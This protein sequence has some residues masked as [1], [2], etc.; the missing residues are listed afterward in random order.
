[1][2]G[3]IEEVERELGTVLSS[4]NQTIKAKDAQI[5]SL[6]EQLKAEKEFGKRNRESK[7]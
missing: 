3:H 1:M 4:A 6:R 2:L 5:E 7:S